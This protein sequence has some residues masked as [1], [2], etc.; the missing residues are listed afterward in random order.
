MSRNNPPFVPS[1][2]GITHFYKVEVI[3]C[4]R[5]SLG[6]F[7]ALRISPHETQDNIHCGSKQSYIYTVQQVREAAIHLGR[8]S[9][10]VGLGGDPSLIPE[11]ERTALRSPISS[12]EEAV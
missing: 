5:T 8:W 11:E 6:K 2:K 9:I 4:L 7:D 12:G 10:F 1:W 3:A